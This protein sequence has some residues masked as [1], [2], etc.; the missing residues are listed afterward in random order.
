MLQTVAISEIISK[1]PIL[2]FICNLWC[3]IVISTKYPSADTVP[4]SRG[5]LFL[6]FGASGAKFN[7]RVLKNSILRQFSAI[8]DV[9]IK[10]PQTSH[11]QRLLGMQRY[12]CTWSF[13]TAGAEFIMVEPKNP[14]LWPFSVIFDVSLKTSQIF[15]AHRLLRTLIH[16]RTLSFSTTVTEFVSVDP[17]NTF[18]YSFLQFFMFHSDLRKVPTSAFVK[19][20][21]I[22]MY[23]KFQ[24]RSYKI[25]HGRAGDTYIY[26]YIYI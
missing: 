2:T 18:C 19:D 23:V 17:E 16:T 25:H 8:Y 7:P 11:E 24:G 15:H 6:K 3:F 22:H 9:S 10:P 26:I 13:T 5:H 20:S 4:I 12:T 14:V 21:K 1:T